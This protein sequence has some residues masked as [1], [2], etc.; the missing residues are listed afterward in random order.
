MANKAEIY[1][2]SFRFLVATTKK[3]ANNT[4]FVEIFQQQ[5]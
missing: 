4:Y 5:Q 3:A 2:Q 1:M